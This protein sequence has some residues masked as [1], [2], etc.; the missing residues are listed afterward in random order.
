MP[1]ILFTG[2]TNADILPVTRDNHSFISVI[3]LPVIRI[4]GILVKNRFKIALATSTMV[5]M[6]TGFFW[7]PLSRV[8]DTAGF[9]EL[10]PFVPLCYGVGSLLGI[11]I[12][13]KIAFDPEKWAF[14]SAL[15]VSGVMWSLAAIFKWPSSQDPLLLLVIQT[16]YGGFSGM[17]Y[18]STDTFYRS[19]LSRRSKAH[20]RKVALLNTIFPFTLTFSSLSFWVLDKKLPTY[21]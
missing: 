11:W 19:Q 12:Y 15:G 20:Q 3:L 17:L 18:T 4:K 10:V 16:L 8:F 2:Y 9:E 5:G 21:L 7:S 1:V 13:T 14:L 6:M